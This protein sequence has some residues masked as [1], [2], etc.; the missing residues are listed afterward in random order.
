ML[1]F[2]PTPLGNLEDITFRALK[3]LKESQIIFCEDTRVTKKLL[4]L[5]HEKFHI[6]FGDKRFISLHQHNEDEVLQKLDSSIF[7][8]NCVYV[9]DAGMPA[10]SDPGAKL[11]RF[12]QEHGISYEVLPGPSAGVTAFAASGFLQKEF[13]FFGFL[14]HKARAREEQ[15]RRILSHEEASVLYEAPHRLLRLLEE[16]VR[17]DSQRELFLAKELSKKYETYYKGKA[18]DLY[19][20]L[21]DEEI[22]GEWVLVIEGNKT[23]KS[24]SLT[25]QDIASLSLPKKEK[26]KLIAKLTG[27]NIKDIYN[28][29]VQKD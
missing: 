24:S 1:S 29:L 4:H 22:K 15:L 12:A 17:I 25:P 26:A 16:I 21:K 6:D 14:P 9:S 7:E 2:V 19:N 13:C 5:L 23:S 27:E 3:T 8:K 11:V 20:R 28:R 10:I 18:Q